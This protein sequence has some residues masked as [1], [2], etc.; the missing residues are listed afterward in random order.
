LTADVQHGTTNLS[1]YRDRVSNVVA[2]G[3]QDDSAPACRQC[4]GAL[5]EHPPG[6][7]GRPPKYCSVIC[8]QAAHRARR[9]YSAAQ[10]E[11]VK[12]P[13]RV[14]LQEL[15][16]NLRQHTGKLDQRLERYGAEAQALVELAVAVRD[17]AAAHDRAVG[18]SWT[19]VARRVDTT[20]AKV[21]DHCQTGL[22][23]VVSMSERG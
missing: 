23:L 20:P 8:R 2:V 12:R 16:E 6:H 4:G 9:R 1:E 7:P 22:E 14:A 17:V 15:V 10:P 18:D 19:A 3:S 5:A 21:Q 11:H 13:F